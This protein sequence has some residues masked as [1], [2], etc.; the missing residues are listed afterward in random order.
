MPRCWG[1]RGGSV[2]ERDSEPAPRYYSTRLARCPKITQK[3]QK[4]IKTVETGLYTALLGEEYGLVALQQLGA[5]A[6]CRGVGWQ[7]V[8]RNSTIPY[9][10][11]G[12]MGQGSDP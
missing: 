8:A 12:F 11:R 7:E 3:K 6:A 5:P 10:T 2:T 9:P 4:Y 1:Q